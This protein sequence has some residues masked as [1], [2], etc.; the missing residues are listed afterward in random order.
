MSRSYVEGI[1]RVALEMMDDEARPLRPRVEAG[2]VHL[3]PR[4]TSAFGDF[5]DERDR[6]LW[7]SIRERLEIREPDGGRG[8]I[9]TSL[10]AIS[11]AQVFAI[12]ADVRELHRRIAER[13][14]SECYREP[15]DEADFE[16]WR[17]RS[18][19]V[20]DLVPFCP[21]CDNR[22]FGPPRAR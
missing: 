9:S 2:L 20:G 15:V 10:A 17:C 7:S 16:E 8:S 3:A 19:G 21:Q 6:L 18:D 11:D 14:C 12:V 5:T 13:V 22:E 1:L 4:L